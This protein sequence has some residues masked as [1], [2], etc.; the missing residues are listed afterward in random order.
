MKKWP[1]DR[2]GCPL[3]RIFR[4]YRIRY[5]RSF[6]TKKL[7]RKNRNLMFPSVIMRFPLHLDPVL[8]ISTVRGLTFLWDCF[9]CRSII[10]WQRCALSKGDAASWSVVA[11]NCLTSSYD[12]L[13]RIK[14]INQAVVY[15][16]YYTSFTKGFCSV[17]FI[18]LVK[19]K[20]KKSTQLTFFCAKTASMAST[21]LKMDNK[22]VCHALLLLLLLLLLLFFVLLFSF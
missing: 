1:R 5:W 19:H 21:F 4:Y 10:P 16:V 6:V 17:E 2:Q 20:R 18:W 14:E 12:M 3:L 7:K 22:I 11:S 15:N 9:W 13:K 8:R